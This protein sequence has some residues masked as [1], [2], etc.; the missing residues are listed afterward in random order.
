MM[1]KGETV[2]DKNK[3]DLENRLKFLES[4]VELSHE[5]ERNMT[6]LLAYLKSV[7]IRKYPTVE[8][9]PFGS[10]AC[11]LGFHGSDLDI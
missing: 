10:S 5:D 3:D 9:K 1:N 11:D 8:V 6:E 7:V 2:F 4:L